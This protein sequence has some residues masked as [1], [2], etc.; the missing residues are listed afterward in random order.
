MRD[1]AVRSV[2]AGQHGL[3]DGQLVCES[4]SADVLSH[5]RRHV[6]RVC[7][8]THTHTSTTT[9]YSCRVKQVCN[10]S[11]I[12][13]SKMIS[14]YYFLTNKRYSNYKIYISLIFSERKSNIF[15]EVFFPIPF[16]KKNI[17]YYNLKQEILIKYASYFCQL[18]FTKL[19]D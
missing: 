11:D 7:T 5:T 16:L 17:A 6:H 3:S 8:H 15:R 1:R 13:T 2:F 4:R 18:S 12:C 14:F 19:T 9:T 10:G